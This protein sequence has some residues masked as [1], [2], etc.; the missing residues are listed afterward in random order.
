MQDEFVKSDHVRR[1]FNPKNTYDYAGLS[2]ASNMAMTTHNILAYERDL[3]SVAR[4]FQRG[5]CEEIC[6]GHYVVVPF[7]DKELDGNGTV[8]ALVRPTV[9][10]QHAVKLM[11]LAGPW[12]PSVVGN[13]FGMFDPKTMIVQGDIMSGLNTVFSRL[14]MHDLQARHVLVS[15]RTYEV[16][17]SITNIWGKED[18]KENKFVEDGG[19]WGAKM[20][21]SK[22]ISN[23]EIF[24]SAA[25]EYVGVYVKEL[26][27]SKVPTGRFG[28][29]LI[30]SYSVARL[31]LPEAWK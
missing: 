31:D 20:L 22:H 25:P 13:F 4:C 3:R 7:C 8:M 9:D 18:K 2:F 24:V 29:S 27:A 14:E 6:E 16:L 10:Q 5:C 15:P 12:K 21:A 19:F 17:D 11:E 30:N 23:G 1:K 28:M 26:D